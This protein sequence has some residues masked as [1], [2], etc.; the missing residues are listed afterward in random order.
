[1]LASILRMNGRISKIVYD[2][3]IHGSNVANVKEF[4]VYFLAQR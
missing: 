2:V 3:M 1:M 4:V